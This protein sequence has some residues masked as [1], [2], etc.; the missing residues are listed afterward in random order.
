LKYVVR[1][2]SVF[3]AVVQSAVMS[4]TKSLVLSVGVFSFFV[5]PAFMAPAA[6]AQEPPVGSAERG[7]RLAY[8]CKGC[9]AIPNYKNVYPTYSVPKLKGQHPD[10][11]V[12]ALQGYRSSERSHATMHAHAAS[13]SDQDMADIAAYLSG[14]PIQPDPNRKAIGT[15]PKAA[16]VCVACHGNDGVGI[17]P[18][19]PTLSGQHRDYLE[20]S[21][22]DYK[23]GT[24]KNPVMAGFVATLTPADIK[25]LADYYAEQR[26]AL[27]TTPKRVTRF[28]AR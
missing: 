28:S 3:R 11:L 8:T 4:V 23:R 16:E 9:H 19:Y 10:Y 22:H 25:A 21:L 26:P 1:G 2:R 20:R 24:R 18:L 6:F 14:A 15:P 12:I 17:V 7:S 27:E 13:M 5:V